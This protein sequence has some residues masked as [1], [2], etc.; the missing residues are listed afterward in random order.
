MTPIND[1]AGAQLEAA[2]I[3][4]TDEQ[5]MLRARLFAIKEI[6]DTVENRCMAVD[7]PVTNTRVEMSDAELQRIYRLAGGTVQ[8]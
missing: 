4:A 3:A 2:L 6:I 1:P 7:G 5:A 8:S